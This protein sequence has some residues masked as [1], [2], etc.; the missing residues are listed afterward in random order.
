MQFDPSN[1]PTADAYFFQKKHPF[2]NAIWSFRPSNCRCICFPPKKPPPVHWPNYSLILPIADVCVFTKQKKQRHPWPKC[3]FILP[4]ADAYDSKRKC[5]AWPHC[6]LILP[7][8][9]IITQ[10]KTKPKE[11]L[12]KMQF[13]LILPTADACVAKKTM[14]DPSNCRCICCHHKKNLRNP[15]PKYSLIL[16]TA[17]KRE[18]PF[19]SLNSHFW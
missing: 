16:P 14:F 8:A 17:K 9:D 12:A 5:V 6:S 13:G 7:T 19:N 3:S 10:K 18:V 11:S 4:T 2:Q 15:W 1:L